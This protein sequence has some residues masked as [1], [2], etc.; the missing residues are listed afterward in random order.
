MI[1]KI[2][3]NQIT[4]NSNENDNNEK[5]FISLL[6]SNISIEEKL[7]IISKIT[8]QHINEFLALLNIFEDMIKISDNKV[9]NFKSLA[10]LFIHFI[11]SK[12]N[13][14]IIINENVIDKFID[15]NEVS[16]NNIK[17]INNTPM[18]YFNS[19]PLFP[20]IMGSLLLQKE[21]LSFNHNVDLN[22]IE[23]YN[24]YYSSI[25]MLHYVNSL[26]LPLSE[27]EVT[28]VS[29]VLDNYMKKVETINKINK[30]KDDITFK[31]LSQEVMKRFVN[32]HQIAKFFVDN[33]KFDK[34][35]S[36]LYDDNILIYSLN[37]DCKDIL[38][39]MNKK[40]NAKSQN[41]K[42]I[43]E[44]VLTC[45]DI[46]LDVIGRS[47]NLNNTKDMIQYILYYPNRLLAEE[48]NQDYIKLIQICFKFPKIYQQIFS[49]SRDRFVEI[50]DAK[51]F[52]YWVKENLD[53]KKLVFAINQY[54]KN[55]RLNKNVF[56]E[57]DK[58][59]ERLDSL[60]YDESFV[61]ELQ[62]IIVS[63]Y[64]Q[65][66]NKRLKIKV[67]EYLI[68]YIDKCN[69]QSLLRNIQD[70]FKPKHKK[71]YDS[72]RIFFIE[73]G[74]E[75]LLPMLEVMKHN[76][77]FNVK[78]N[79]TTKTFLNRIQNKIIKNISS[80]YEFVR[81]VCVNFRLTNNINLKFFSKYEAF[82]EKISI[83]NNQAFEYKSINLVLKSIISSISKNNISLKFKNNLIKY[84]KIIY[85][86]YLIDY[87]I[88]I[89][90][91]YNIKKYLETRSKENLDKEFC[92]KYGYIIYMLDV[93]L[94]HRL[95]DDDK[96][97]KTASKLLIWCDN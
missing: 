86:K 10:I 25:L 32:L 46:L 16:I 20:W 69:D 61:I 96:L 81:Y 78:L 91:K 75:N 6:N 56:Y 55:G 68:D 33:D 72:K 92:N 63:K 97:T 45:R 58:I 60:K 76:R 5:N 21:I 82:K 89:L 22:M 13:S 3:S 80:F 23:N 28:Q 4:P 70:Y 36:Y 84:I 35:K 57:Y 52:K 66:I 11:A 8:S 9:S 62:T 51:E 2:E 17:I 26:Y 94:Y 43:H 83:K 24:G 53:N 14:E 19:Q 87:E 85:D 31:T 65:L 39:L 44:V 88:K 40:S 79:N 90:F 47:N 71:K 30:K 12:T 54:L 73:N 67:R 42:D 15:K 1:N 50:C 37:N 18:N 38:D 49:R 77:Y 27:H 48:I 74:Y 7:D 64:K 41:L 95:L 93:I 59:F 29:H 34:I